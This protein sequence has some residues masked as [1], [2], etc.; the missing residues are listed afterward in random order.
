MDTSLSRLFKIFSN[1]IV[2]IIS[3]LIC[4]GLG[5]IIY[6]INNHIQFIN[7]NS[8]NALLSIIKSS[9]LDF[10]LALGAAILFLILAFF[11]IPVTFKRFF[12]VHIVV[13]ALLIAGNIIGYHYELGLQV[14]LVNVIILIITVIIIALSIAIS[15]PN[16]N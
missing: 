5:Y 3:L 2:Y 9:P 6:S 10:F 8:W 15:L 14:F 12:K 4:T 1:W 13:P 11:V 7:I 16:N